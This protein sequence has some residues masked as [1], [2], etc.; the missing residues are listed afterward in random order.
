MAK[1]I[2]DETLK[3]NI[4]I[5]GDSAKKEYGQLERANRSLLNANEDL[6]AQA[7]KLEKANKTTSDS[8]KDLQLKIAANSKEVADNKNKMSAL[9]KE[10]G[11]NNLSMRELSNEARKLNGIMSNLD[12]NSAE[13]SRYN[14]ELQSVRG[15]MA[16]LRDEM[17]PVSDA[18][19]DQISIVENLGTG[20][21][22][23]FTGLKTGDIKGAAQGFSTVANG[24]GAATKA[25]WAFI[26][27]PIGA[28]LA[29][30]V[31]S[32]GAIK[33]WADYNE[34]IKESI[35]LTEQ[36]TKLQGDQ[37]EK[38]RQQ[39]TVLEDVYGA[40]FKET[41][42]VAN[43]LVK[44][45]G[46]TFPEA[47]DEIEKGLQKGQI[48]NSE[49]F[50]SLKEY[51]TFFANA[52]FSIGEFRKVVETGYDLG[53]YSDKL[54]DA[55]KEFDLSIKEQTPAVKKALENAF[56]GA[57]TESL[58]ARVNK[59]ETTTKKA[60]AEI[61]A[62]A[63]KSNIT[64]QQNAQ[65]TADLFR[66]AGEDAG[67]ALKVFEAMNIALTDQERALTPLEEM[68]KEV[69]DAH[70]DLEAAQSEALKSDKYL[71]LSSELSVFWIKTK[72]LF[73]Q[74]L[75]FIV[76]TFTSITDTIVIK[77][78]QISSV[79]GNLPTIAKIA[80]TALK[81]EVFDVVKTFGG[82]ADVVENLMDFNF[83]G[84]K[85]AF[86]DFKEAFKKE[87]SE[88]G[89]VAK[90]IS[91][92]IK[93]SYDAVG[94]DVKGKLDKRRQGAVDQDSIAAQNASTANTIPGGN[95]NTTSPELSKEDQSKL[96][97]RKKLAELLDAFDAERELQ[98]QVKKVLK[99]Q[100][101]EEEEVLRLEAKFLKL[102][103]EAAGE[104]ELIARLEDE[105]QLQLQDIRAKY[106]E[107]H[108]L[109]E[110]EEQDRLSKQK[111]AFDEKI[112]EG[113][114]KLNQAKENAKN[115]GINILR[116]ALGE[117]S[118]IGKALFV[119]Q[120]GMA[121]GGIIADA[122]KAVAAVTANT[123]IANSVALAA[124][125]LTFGQPFVAANT[126]AAATSIAATKIAAATQIAAIAAQGITGF[127]DGLYPTK[128]KQ[129]GKMFNARNGGA[130][131]TQ[132]VSAPTTFLAGEVAPEM[133]IDGNTFKKMDPA[134]TNYIL[135]LAGKPVVG[136]EKGYYQQSEQTGITNAQN[137]NSI[138]APVLNRLIEKLNEPIKAEMLY[139]ADASRKQKEYDDKI[140]S[141][142]TNAKIKN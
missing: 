103:E 118:A 26:T 75:S 2:T 82:L 73:Y 137:D 39:A 130:P 133:I 42:T 117:S 142:R 101:A 141:T 14:T 126:A 84:A 53:V 62:Q 111:Q 3:F 124:S 66:G 22:Q 54:P 125:P 32:V 48:N 97:S 127:E 11:L 79:I 89:G 9:T 60:L 68:I 90:E 37:A 17:R 93:A 99:A 80:F 83:S 140:T 29:V 47:L 16:N 13:W 34:G 86:S 5:N 15:R 31:A 105:K 134:I 28:A 56:G 131:N 110:K 44:D 24:I 27:T 8:Y 77:F 20:F 59:G 49:Y 69:A 52:G 136:F 23:I 65:L 18:M 38:V 25:A 19:D 98:E 96:S 55:I 100:Q 95:T 107:E 40:D 122:S 6:E 116:N 88:V 1:K 57:F 112:I 21:S 64:I 45:F 109:A 120:K 104:T 92:R 61:A 12:P 30:I 132:I 81:D 78:Y 114:K 76:D 50:D 121:I 113:E 33:F 72:T 129:D 41:L 46:I 43:G 102:T 71:S 108:V 119:I 10:I 115:V 4:I 74:S 63:G 7:K 70:K 106:A 94:A 67:G 123:A 128:R 51:D 135:G 91:D 36:I 87:A 58:L 35:I 85:T 138:L 139:G